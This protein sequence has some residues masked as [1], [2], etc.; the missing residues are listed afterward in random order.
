[1]LSQANSISSWISGTEY[2][3][4]AHGNGKGIFLCRFEA[5]AMQ[6]SSGR[7]S[8]ITDTGTW[9]R[10]GHPGLPPRGAHAAEFQDSRCGLTAYRKKMIPSMLLTIHRTIAVPDPAVIDRCIGK[11]GIPCQSLC[12][13]CLAGAQRPD[14]QDFLGF[15]FQFFCG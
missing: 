4:G 10:E 9:I 12:D 11:T 8:Q 5:R 6:V 15:Y 13:R 7:T 2:A 3:I 1:M 14:D